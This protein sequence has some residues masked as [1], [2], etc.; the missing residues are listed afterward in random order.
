MRRASP[1]SRKGRSPLTERSSA[2][3]LR[4]LQWAARARARQLFARQVA[5]EEDANVEVAGGDGG[6]VGAAA[7][8]V[9]AA[10]LAGEDQL[11]EADDAAHHVVGDVVS[12]AR[13][14]LDAGHKVVERWLLVRR[15]P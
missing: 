14:Q 15:E 2:T 10:R 5:G 4:D 3:A 8:E 9:V 7:L 12:S 1:K 6:A 11:E 13:E